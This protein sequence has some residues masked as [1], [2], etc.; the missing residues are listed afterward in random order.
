[1]YYQNGRVTRW[2]QGGAHKG[3]PQGRPE[4]NTPLRHF[5][6]AAED[7]GQ[8]ALDVGLGRGP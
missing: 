8:A 6:R 1:M 5:A 3:Q 2:D 4:S 7:G